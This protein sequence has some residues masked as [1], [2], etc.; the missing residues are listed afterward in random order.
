M[1]V[2]DLGAGDS[3]DHRA[4][5]T[6]DL[7]TDAD[8]EADLNDDWPLRAESVTGLICNHTLE[9]LDDPVHF[10]QEAGRVLEPRGWVEITVPLGRDAAAD[11]DHSA[12]YPDRG[13][14]YWTPLTFSYRHREEAERPWNPELPFVVERRE[15]DVWLLPPFHWLSGTFNRLADRWPA[16]AAHRCGA[17]EL[18]ALFRKMD[19]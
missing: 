1:R 11:P 6:L 10:F 12:W 17:G 4:T 18:T 13:W 16:W 5:E 8:I 14:T 19:P 2:I 3:P 15:L 9:H 7:H